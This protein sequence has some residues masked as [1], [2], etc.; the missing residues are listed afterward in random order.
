MYLTAMVTALVMYVDQIHA[1]EADTYSGERTQ[2]RSIYGP[3]TLLCDH[4]YIMAV[5]LGICP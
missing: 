2:R 4:Y 1:N 5:T 3:D